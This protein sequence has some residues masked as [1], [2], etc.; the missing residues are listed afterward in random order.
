MTKIIFHIYFA[1]S[2]TQTKQ[3]IQLYEGACNKHLK[4]GSFE[5]NIID[6]IKKPEWAEKHKILATP[7]ISRISP[8]PEKRIIG[9]L[10]EEQANNAVRFLTE[11]L[12]IE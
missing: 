7:T 3:F 8:A 12:S 4:A 5:I 1:G 10:N 6:I 2:S 11:D 9:K